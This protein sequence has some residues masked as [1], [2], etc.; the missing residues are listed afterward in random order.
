MIIR[1]FLLSL[2]LLM[3]C[4]NGVAQDSGQDEFAIG[5]GDTIVID[6]YN[7]RDLYVETQV[8]ATGVVK[9]P[10]IREISVVG[11]TPTALEVEI[12]AALFDGYLVNPDVFVKIKQYRSFFI[13]GEVKLPGAYDFKLNLTVDQAIAIAGGLTERASSKNWFIL[14]DVSDKPLDV[15]KDSVVFPGDVIQIE[16][17][18]F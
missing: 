4:F 3:F 17:S 15:G 13:K 9:V 11:K 12:E 1:L 18:M 16:R 14:R 2:M 10:L 7:E 8:D 6:V 5:V